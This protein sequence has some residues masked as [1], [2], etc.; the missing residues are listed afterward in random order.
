MTRHIHCGT[1]CPQRLPLSD[2]FEMIPSTFDGPPSRASSLD[3]DVCADPEVFD[4]WYAK[5]TSG[6]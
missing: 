5:E 1:Y 2:G 6:G 3:G 4:G